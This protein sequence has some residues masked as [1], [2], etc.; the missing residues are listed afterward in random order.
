MNGEQY[1]I[2]AYVVGVVVLWG[3]GALLWLEARAMTRAESNAS[4]PAAPAAPA[5]EE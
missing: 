1:L 3:Y 5:L 4:A 2:M